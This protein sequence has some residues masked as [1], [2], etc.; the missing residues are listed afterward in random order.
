MIAIIP[1]SASSRVVE[2]E[3]SISQLWHLLNKWIKTGSEGEP[4]M[5]YC[6]KKLLYAHVNRDL[7]LKKTEILKM[8]YMDTDMLLI[9]Y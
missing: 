1:R 5:D 4:R 6:S 9:G 2:G 7:K 3:A 8:V